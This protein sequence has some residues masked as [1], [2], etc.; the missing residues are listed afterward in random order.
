MKEWGEEFIDQ[1]NRIPV[2][3][4]GIADCNISSTFGEDTLY[5]LINV[6]GR[7]KRNVVKNRMLFSNF[8]EWFNSHPSYNLD[9]EYDDFEGNKHMLVFNIPENYQGIIEKFIEGKYSQLYDRDDVDRLISKTIKDER[10]KNIDLTND[11]YFILTRNPAFREK[12]KKQLK[13]DFRYTGGDI[14]HDA[15]Y[16]YPPILGEEVF[17]YERI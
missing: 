15:E 11:S 1:V 8:L 17:N 2:L 5:C 10:N 9:Y 12:F 4:W 7:D 14:L 16:D 13:Q 6:D 3:A